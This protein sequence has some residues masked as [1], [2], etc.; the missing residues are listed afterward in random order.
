[1]HLVRPAPVQVEV[2][3]ENPAMGR[4]AIRAGFH[5]GKIVASVVGHATPRFCLFGDTARSPPPCQAP[6]A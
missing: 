1:M 4:V 6:R 3:P 5:C 2:L